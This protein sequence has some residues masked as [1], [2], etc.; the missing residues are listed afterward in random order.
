M[1]EKDSKTAES[2]DAKGETPL[3]LSEERAAAERSAAPAYVSTRRTALALGALAIALGA[4]AVV[5]SRNTQDALRLA[6]GVA[7]GT[8]H[9]LGQAIQRATTALRGARIDVLPTLGSVQ[10]IEMLEARTADLALVSSA[11]PA[12]KG[13]SMLCPLGDEYV[14]LI[15]RKSLQI[16]NPVEL[17]GKRV[18]LGPPSSGTRHAGL[19]VLS[20]FG[21]TEQ[22]IQMLP[23]SPHAAQQAFERGEADA[24]FLLCTL[25]DPVAAALLA[26]GDCEL[27]SLGIPEQAGSSLEGICASVPGLQRAVIP[28][29][30]YGSAPPQAIGTVRGTTYLLA[31][32]DLPDSL[33]A[34]VTE[35]IFRNK[36]ELSRIDPSLARMSEEFDRASALYPVHVGADQY[37][38]RDAPTLVERYS[39]A[40]SLAFSALAV[41]WSGL[42]AFHSARQR[43][44]LHRL[45]DVHRECAELELRSR[46]VQ[47]R[48]ER[49]AVYDSADALRT[50]VFD[51]LVAGNFIADEAFRVLVLRLD[52]LIARNDDIPGMAL[53]P[54]ALETSRDSSPRL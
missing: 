20:H 32:E 31:R 2:S 52:A 24:V 13:V 18:S 8:S 34:R 10:N 9:A 4:G 11:L 38:R 41:L 3:S 35:Q 53:S 17:A 39:D 30:V 50:R 36:V 48:G 26:R 12:G 5:W 43:T 16:K 45:E 29:F 22:S 28:V 40:I 46:E 25:P 47:S 15:V 23:L 54:H 19:S 14:H 27:L 7:D 33:V 1:E 49:R 6:T 44:R 37:F 21:L 51:A 42:R